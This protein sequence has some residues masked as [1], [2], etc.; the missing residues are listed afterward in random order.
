M[1]FRS[2]ASTLVTH[3]SAA[4]VTAVIEGIPVIVS[5]MSALAQMRWSTDPEHDQRLGFLNVLADNQWT[6]DE[7][8][9][10]KAWEWLTK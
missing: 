1:L 3:S 2:G 9:E 7:I 5:G 4:A 6:L 10:G 8:R